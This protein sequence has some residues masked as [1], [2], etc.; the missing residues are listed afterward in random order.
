MMTMRLQAE[1]PRTI[2]LYNPISG[3]GHLDSWNALFV[4]ALLNAG[5]VVASMSPGAVDLRIRLKQKGMDNHPNLR[6]LDWRTP[7]RSLQHRV[8]SR[9][10]R[11][12]K[13][14]EQQDTADDAVLKAQYLQPIEFAQRIQDASRQLRS[15]PSFV[16]NMYMDLYRMDELGWAPFAIENRVPWAGIRFVPKQV[17][18]TPSTSGRVDDSMEA[19]YNNPTLSGMCFLD[20]EVCQRYTALLPQKKFG[21]LPD[22]TESAMPDRVSP[23]RREIQQLAAGRKI[24]FL[25][26][27]IGANKNLS[28]WYE[29]IALANRQDWFFVQVGEIHE[30]N[31]PSEDLTALK[32]IKS[33]TPENVYLKTEYIP[34]ERVF[35]DLISSSDVLFAVYRNFAI[36]SNMLGKAATFEKPIIVAEGHLMG[37]RV[38]QYQIGLTVPENST[39]HMLDALTSLAT[40]PNQ[41]AVGQPAHF[42]AY[43]RDFSVAAL[44]KH[45]FSFLEKAIPL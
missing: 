8:R 42:A 1:R 18:K 5:W 33:N 29:L 41:R 14:Q 28:Q 32:E 11:L 37:S 16:F 3:H 26:G 30:G 43:R 19:F 2:L 35:N 13:R 12:F 27:T 31:L 25:G 17:A 6:V 20:A 34:D 45:F 21:Y 39:K 4:V 23:L 10:S 44:E 7:K 15:Q 22:I 40:P 24:V 36:S 38:E 9:I